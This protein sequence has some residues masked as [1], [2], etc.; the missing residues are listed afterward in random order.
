MAAQ[1]GASAHA[2]PVAVATS[3]ANTATRH[4]R[5]T[6]NVR[7]IRIGG[8][9]RVS[10]VSAAHAVARPAPAPA[11]AT[12]RLSRS[13]SRTTRRRGPPRASRT[14]ISLARLAP[15]ASSSPATLKAAISRTRPKK[16]KS[17]A[18]ERLTY[19]RRATGSGPSGSASS[20]WR[21]SSPGCSRTISRAIRAMSLRAWMIGTP[22]RRR[23]IPISHWRP[24]SPIRVRSSPSR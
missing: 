4:V 10:S 1:A 16:P 17:S 5:P 23:P 18:S 21:T 6:S 13:N 7:S 3:S 22:G 12:I 19:G 2:T 8:I 11:T 20:P 14:P 15:R 9:D 24:R